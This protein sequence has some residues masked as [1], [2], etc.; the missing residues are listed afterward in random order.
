MSETHQL[1]EN[2]GWMMLF[3]CLMVLLGIFAVAYAAGARFPGGAGGIG[4]PLRCGCQGVPLE[5]QEHQLLDRKKGD[6]NA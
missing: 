6:G 3:G 2:W 4:R 5:G 1:R